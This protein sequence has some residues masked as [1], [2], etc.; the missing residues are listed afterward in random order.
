M[1][2]L[3]PKLTQEHGKRG[4][5]GKGF[6]DTLAGVIAADNNHKGIVGIAY[7][8]K[9]MSVKAGQ[10][11]GSFNQ[12]TVAKA[13]LYAYDNGA[14]IINMSFGGSASS[15]AVQDALATAYTRCVQ[16]YAPGEGIVS[17]IPGNRHA[18]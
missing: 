17:T 4:K 13:I 15:I 8:T 7:N 5:D 10:S 3:S 14:D 2:L 1:G 9:T 11:S 16:V 12:A 18:T 6:I